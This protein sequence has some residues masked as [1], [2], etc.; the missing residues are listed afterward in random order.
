MNRG[1]VLAFLLPLLLPMFLGMGLAALGC[2]S[3]TL[4]GS[5][6]GRGGGGAT[7]SAGVGG[8]RDGGVDGGGCRSDLFVD[9]QIESTTGGAVT[10]DAVKAAQVVVNIDGVNYPQLCPAGHSSGSQD[11]LLQMNNAIYAVT[12]NLEDMTGNPLAVPQ[13]TQIDVTSCASY[14]TPG[15]ATLVVSPS[16]Q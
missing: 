10:C 5:D 11:I 4:H 15:P 14:A 1:G 12:V 8:G 2:G 16:A 9:W 3:D 13:S 6:A 7:G